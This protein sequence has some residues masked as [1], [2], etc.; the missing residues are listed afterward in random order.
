MNV[1]CVKTGEKYNSDY[2]YRLRNMVWRHLPQPHRFICLTDR[3]NDLTEVETIDI[4]RFGL[5]GWW[6][7]LLMLDPAMRGHSKA[8]YFDLDTVIVGDLTPLANLKTHF[9]VCENFTKLAGSQTPCNYGSC[10]MVFEATWGYDAWRTFASN[11][12]K[13]M[14][15]A[16]AYGD[17][18]V[19]EALVPEARLL[20]SEMPAGYFLGYRDLKNHPVQPPECSVVVFAGKNKPANSEVGWV[21]ESWR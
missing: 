20:Q 6:A 9:G 12:R 3:P 14:A 1:L 16:G 15:E 18:Y 5:D 7:K 8:L 2:V 13:L 11:R 21:R 19:F 17:Q 4:S 10:T